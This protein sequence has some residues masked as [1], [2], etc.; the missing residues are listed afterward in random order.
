MPPKN[1][2]NPELDAI[3][4]RPEN[5][6]C[7]DCGAKAPRWASVNLGVL[8]CIDCSGQHR[9]LGVHISVVKSVT[10]D[11]W[12]PKWI[13]TVSKVGNRIARDYYEHTLASD[14]K[15]PC[16]G[17]DRNKINTWIRN[18]YER[19]EYAPR[20]KPS[21]GELVAQGRDPDVYGR[22]NGRDREDDSD[23]DR[24]R[25]S[26]R[27]RDRSPEEERRR[28]SAPKQEPKQE[29]PKPVVAPTPTPKPVAPAV[30]L[31]DMEST[32]GPP[33]SASSF[34]FT[35]S[36]PPPQQ[37]QQQN[38]L[39]QV[40]FF[41]GSN[42]N[43][44]APAAAPPTGFPDLF[45]QQSQPP[46]PQQAP[47]P[48]Q[49]EQVQ[50]QKV[51][52]LNNNLG[53][54]YNQPAPDR[55]AAMNNLGGMNNV[56]NMNMMSG[57]GN[58]MPNMGYGMMTGMGA[59]NQMSGFQMPGMNNASSMQGMMPN[60][61]FSQPALAVPQ[62]SP[63]MMPSSMSSTPSPS[64]HMPM[65]MSSS[66]PTP[67]ASSQ[68]TGASGSAGMDEKMKEIM[69]SL[70]GGTPAVS[71][72]RG[73]KNATD[74]S[75]KGNAPNSKGVSGLDAFSMLGTAAP[76]ASSS[77]S[78]PMGN[79]QPMGGMAMGG[80]MGGSQ[81]SM[82]N[83]QQRNQMQQPMGGMPQMGMP[84]MGGMQQMGMQMGMPQM[85]GMQQ[86]NGMQMP[87]MQ[88]PMGGYSANGMAPP[89]GGMPCAAGGFGFVS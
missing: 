26:D 76:S 54:L 10:L 38:S 23:D 70:G 59:Q 6:V 64:P 46:M 20:N 16:E 68:S 39:Q 17:D 80:M 72:R 11:K 28:S 13:N 69:E 42:G 56:G 32:S 62:Q 5:L 73:T 29:A 30:N 33:P 31:L 57:M 1:N 63:A 58:M 86:M 81:P 61:F 88:A 37:T 60:G 36:Q 24:R 67:A 8:V 66:T 85:G 79:M 18:K 21:P 9:N 49:Q 34:S 44:A 2:V 52:M 77:Q 53:A 65:S 35:Q 89:Y 71:E 75:P 48:V 27:R 4:K 43:V 41:G 45:A 83:M 25:R 7:A 78:R 47:Q 87:G 84:Q 74:T 19:K 55:F 14:Y 15:R 22:D 82:G 51:N 12:N 50:D 3:C 40:N